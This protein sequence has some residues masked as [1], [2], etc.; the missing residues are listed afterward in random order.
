MKALRLLKKE[1]S[2][3]EDNESKV[4]L[5]REALRNRYPDATLFIIMG[6]DTFEA[7]WDPESSPGYVYR[8]YFSKDRSLQEMKRLQPKEDNPVADRYY[9]IQGTMQE[10]TE[11]KLEVRQFSPWDV[12]TRILGK[13]FLELRKIS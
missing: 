11:G 4:R 10:L 6:W 9:L 5:L 12:E 2:K 13:L 7:S 8:A 3:E 1:I